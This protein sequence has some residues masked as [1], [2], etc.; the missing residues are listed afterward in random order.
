MAAKRELDALLSNA[1]TVATL[2]TFYVRE[3]RRIIDMLS[4]EISR[5]GA[6]RA[7]ALLREINAAIDKLDPKKAS[8]VRNWIRK[9]IPRA[10]V[11]G[12]RAATRQLREDLAELTAEERREFGDINRTFTGANRTAMQGIAAAMADT[13]G[14]VADQLRRNMGLIIRRTQQ[15]LVS[16]SAIREV[17]V[18]GIIRGATGK[19]VA[20]DIASILLGKKVKP[21]VRKRLSEVGFRA[22]MFNE[23]EAIARGE[24][25]TVG[26][27]R[28][29]VRNYAN[30][31]ARTQMREAHRVGAIVRLQ[32][33]KNDYVRVSKHVQKEPDECTPF[34]GRVFYIGPLEKDPRGFPKLSSLPNGGPPFHPN[35]GHVL[36]P[37]LVQF[38]TDEQLEKDQELSKK[39]TRK[40][41][42]KTNAEVRRIVDGLSESELD[43]LAA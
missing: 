29:N 2:E 22:E 24:M 41:F 3:V 36:E 11:L 13:L 40:F 18:G 5:P 33:N 19:Q 27:R 30:L 21:E 17:T 7:S 6:A 28:F 12:D 31:V 20:D 32:K 14:N 37:F 26:K 38:E 35:C 4:S 1:N 39:L 10:F 25:I 23:F 8:S 9:N 42:G 43:D 16:N 15:V 34:Q